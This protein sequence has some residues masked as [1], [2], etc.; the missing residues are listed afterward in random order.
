MTPDAIWVAVVLVLAALAF[1]SERFPPEMVGLA[2]LLT[3]VVVGVIQVPVALSGFSNQ[4]TV[5]VAAMFVLSA[6][7]QQSGALAPL[8]RGLMRYGRTPLSLMLILMLVAGAVSAFV[9]NTAAVAV[10]MPLA[11][12]AANHHGFSPSK[13]LIPLS[14]ASQFG[15]VCTLIGTSTNLLVAGIAHDAG[16]V[17]LTMF[18]PTLLGLLMSAIGVLYLLTVGSWLLPARVTG[19]PLESYRVQDYV[20]ELI[21]KPDSELVGQRIRLAEV[22]KKYGLAVVDVIRDDVR[23][24]SPVDVVIRAGDV[25]LLRGGAEDLMR[26]KDR[27]ALGLV[28][29]FT[30]DKD[31]LESQEVRLAE[32]LI[33]PGSRHHGR[34][35]GDLEIS[36][37]HALRALAVRRRA[38]LIRTQLRAHELREGDVLLVLVPKDR[39]A[40]LR[41]DTDLIALDRDEGTRDIGRATWAVAIMACVVLSAALNL[42]PMVV[43]AMVGVLAMVAT[44]CLNLEQLYK[45]IDWRV[46]LLLAT[47]IPLGAAMDSSGL[48]PAIAGQLLTFVEDGNP[49]IALAIIYGITAIFTEFMSNNASAVLL[50]PIAI[51]TALTLGVSPMPFLIAVMFAASTSFATPIGYQTNT[52]VHNAGGYRFRDFAMI[53]VP[54]NLLF[55]AAAVW[56]IPKLFPF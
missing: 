9:N 17:E 28:P 45:A 21:A 25:L 20:G 40:A 2:A 54:L 1:F 35:L 3:L 15:G 50:A 30:L 32:V 53:G 49:L 22:E 19:P 26:F 13:I 41:S 42:L 6:G 11:I 8:T 39:L 31:L 23:L 4:A 46:I 14:Y 37:R 51:A 44:R 29:D 12:Q 10:F 56:A 5:T 47:M 24:F 38:T 34:T 27:F 48:A 16:L 36:G 18:A 33:A 55:W 43:A 52:M 7:L